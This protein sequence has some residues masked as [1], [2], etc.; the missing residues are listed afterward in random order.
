MNILIIA[1]NAEGEQTH[2]ICEMTEGKFKKVKTELN[3]IGYTITKI[4]E[5]GQELVKFVSANG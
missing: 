4:Y 5:L 2:E 3:E 1:E